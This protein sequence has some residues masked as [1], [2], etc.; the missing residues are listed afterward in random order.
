MALLTIDEALSK[1]KKAVKLRQHMVAAD[2]YRAILRQQPGH[3]IAKKGLRKLERQLKRGPSAKVAATEPDP[4]RVNELVELTRLGH[5]QQV[6]MN[7]RALLGDFPNS[8]VILNFLGIALQRQGKLPQA[9]E[10]LDEAIELKPDVV[11]SHS[12]RGIALKELGRAEEALESYDKA[13]ELKPDFTEAH[14]NRG[15][16]LQG[17]GR[18]DEASAS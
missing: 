4:E 6:E 12:N 17:I 3:P 7:A 2:L 15:N 11:E 16:V 14:F 5:M 1:A 9:V 13:I 10:V 8:V 18:F